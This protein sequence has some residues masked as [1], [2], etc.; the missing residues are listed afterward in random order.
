[1]QGMQIEINEAQ[2]AR[3][4]ERCR[5]RNII[6]PTF[7]QMKDP[8]LIPAEIKKIGKEASQ[9]T[10]T[11]PVTLVMAQ[12]EGTEILPGM[13]GTAR[14]SVRLPEDAEA[15]GMQLPATAVFAGKDPEKSYVW[16]IDEQSGQ[17]ARRAV[18][19]GALVPTGIE[20]RQ[21]LETGEWIAVAGVHSLHEGQR[22]RLLKNG[23][24]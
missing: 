13:A 9:A 17:V 12:P 3:T 5:E 11:Y 2:V 24:E 6:I 10:R 21:G 23:G 18:T 20:I 4:V 16:V 8:S 1:M 22:V 7:A 15:V 19:A 14:V